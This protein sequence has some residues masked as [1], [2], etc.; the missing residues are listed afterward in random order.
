MAK[1][2][3]ERMIIRGFSIDQ[4]LSEALEAYAK[5]QDRP[6]SWIIREALKKFL[7]SYQVTEKSS[8]YYNDSKGIL[9]E[10]KQQP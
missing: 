3:E 2:K 7:P 1:N 8:K 9:R 5:S 10:R 4:K 6:V